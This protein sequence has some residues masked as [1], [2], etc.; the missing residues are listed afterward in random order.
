MKYASW[1]TQ[2]ATIGGR[3]PHRR[4]NI[5]AFR[6]GV[7]WTPLERCR[8]IVPGQNNKNCVEPCEIFQSGFGYSSSLNGNSGASQST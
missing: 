2:E 4:M 1:V 7:T 3:A 8:I 6:Y 5:Y